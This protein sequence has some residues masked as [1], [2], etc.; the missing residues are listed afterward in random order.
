MTFWNRLNGAGCEKLKRR[1]KW[2]E[3]YQL[4]IFNFVII[5]IIIIIIFTVGSKEPEG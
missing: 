5:I 4:G 3:C 1:E 2:S